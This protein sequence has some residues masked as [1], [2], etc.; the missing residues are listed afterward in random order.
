M[1][2]IYHCNKIKFRAKDWD[3]R[4]AISDLWEA[5]KFFYSFMSAFFL[6]LK[7]VLLS[8]QGLLDSR[9]ETFYVAEIPSQCLFPSEGRLTRFIS[10]SMK[11]DIFH[12][13]KHENYQSPI[14]NDI[15][16]MRGHLPFLWDHSAVWI[17]GF[18][19]PEGGDGT[20]A[21]SSPAAF[22]SG[23]PCVFR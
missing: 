15:W 6:S 21:A 19:F 9:V 7:W 12:H 14:T 16:D 2:C 4:L 1:V 13:S 22:T 18:P 17:Q 8:K 11:S 3:Q 10:F 20:L 5:H 23:T